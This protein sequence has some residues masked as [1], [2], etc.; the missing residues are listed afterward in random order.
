[1]QPDRRILIAD[2]DRE[3]RSCVVELLTQLPIRLE[4]LQAESG[5]EALTIIRRAG[6]HLALLDMHMPG[7][8]GLEVLEALRR[9]TLT[10][11]C[12]VISGEASEAVRK[13]ALIEGACAVLRKPLE[14]RLLRDEV[15]RVL[16]IDAA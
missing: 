1:M 12:I 13:Q 4:I 9:E 10:V 15:R 6:L 16:R 11:P 8:T 5:D 2:D 7:Q 3:L 14:P